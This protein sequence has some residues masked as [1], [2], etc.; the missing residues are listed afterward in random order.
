VVQTECR[1]IDRES[2]AAGTFES[3][4]ATYLEVPV[5]FFSWLQ[6]MAR[7][8]T[9]GL[10]R[11]PSQI[12][13]ICQRLQSDYSLDRSTVAPEGTIPV[14]WFLTESKRGP[15][16]LF[17]TAATMMLRSLG[18]PAR[19][20]LGYY[21]GPE[22]YDEE[23]DH[24]PVKN[25][26]LHLW[27]EVL[28]ADG[29]WLVIEPTPGYAVLAVRLSW[30]QRLLA[31]SSHAWSWCKKYWLP[32]TIALLVVMVFVVWRRSLF[33][34]YLWVIWNWRMRSSPRSAIIA[35][36][37]LLEQRARLARQPRPDTHT[38]PQ[39]YATLPVDDDLAILARFGELAAYAPLD[40][41]LPDEIPTHCRR[42]VAAWPWKRF[43]PA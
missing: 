1:T 21:A 12:M 11:G 39:W 43:R 25:T 40:L 8:W 7:E 17:A 18:Y 24:T 41:D 10:P 14:Q 22:A 29:H 20:C 2:L 4:S 6:A 32:I 31:W 36:W 15:D 30:T 5:E 19:F 26:D 38:L 27:P 34:G 37:R 28:L 16:Y 42:V 13:A 9:A 35:T 23:T 3:R 33:D